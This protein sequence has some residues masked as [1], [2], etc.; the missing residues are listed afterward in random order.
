M[1]EVRTPR[2]IDLAAPNVARMYDYYLGGKDDFEVDRRAA[3]P[4]QRPP[5]RAGRDPGR[6]GLHLDNDPA[7]VAHGRAPIGAG[8]GHYL[9][10]V[11][12]KDPTAAE[13]LR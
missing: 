6:A 4:R 5:G 8:G 1:E 12:R 3:R 13:G 11:G 7:V 10:G 9:C 2:D